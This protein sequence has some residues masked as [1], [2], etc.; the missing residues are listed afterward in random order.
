MTVVAHDAFEGHKRPIVKITHDS[1]TLAYMHFCT[2]LTIKGKIVPAIFALFQ[3][4]LFCFGWRD[5]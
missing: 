1:M 5:L 4:I 2:F 3:I